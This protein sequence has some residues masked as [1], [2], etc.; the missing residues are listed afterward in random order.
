MADRLE[1]VPV[2]CQSSHVDL[3]GDQSTGSRSRRAHPLHPRD[4]HR[5][6]GTGSTPCSPRTPR[7]TTPSP[8]ASPAPYAEVKPWLAEMLPF[9]PKRMHTLA[10]AR[11]RQVDGDDGDLLGVLPQPDAAAAAARA[12]RRSSSSAASTTTRW[13]GRRTAGAAASCTRSSSGS[14]ACSPW[15]GLPEEKPEGLDSP[16]DRRRSSSTWPRVR[17]RV[18]QAD[19][20]PDRLESGGSAPAG[21]K[22]V[23]S[24]CSTTSAAVRHAVHHA[25]A[26][27]RDGADLVIVASQGGLPKNP[28]WYPNLVANPDVTVQVRGDRRPCAHGPPAGR[29]RRALAAPGRALRRLRQ[30]P[31]VDRPGDPGRGAR[32]SRLNES[33]PRR[34]VPGFRAGR[35]HDSATGRMVA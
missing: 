5:R 35:G 16:S 26:L 10:P 29:A 18:V 17:S 23:P 14:G 12:A 24:C 25:A 28:Q 9:F 19:Q 31:V 6:R 8:A 3:A 34:N 13:R 11:H 32:A 15:L 2:L 22:P 21:R 30:V 1:R 27:P 4:R 33:P 20:R 7:S